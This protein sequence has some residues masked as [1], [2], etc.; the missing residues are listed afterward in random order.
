[1]RS[2]PMIVVVDRIEEDYAVIEFS[3]RTTKDYKLAELPAGTK[4]GDCLN[5]EDGVFTLNSEETAKREKN[6]AELLNSLWE[7]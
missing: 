4:P 2:E 6:A 5:L 7:K 3:D 1:M